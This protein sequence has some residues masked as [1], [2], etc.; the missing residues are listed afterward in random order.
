MMNK[1]LSNGVFCLFHCAV[2]FLLLAASCRAD[3]ACLDAAQR[4]ELPGTSNMYQVSDSLYRGA[5]PKA[6]GFKSLEALEIKTVVNLR[7]TQGDERYAG[8]ASMNLVGIPMFPWEPDEEDVIRFLKLTQDPATAP[9]F[10]H[11]RH[12]SDRTGALTAC[13]RVVVCGWPLEQA[14]EEMKNGGFGYHPI[15]WTLPR[16]LEDLDFDRIRREVFAQ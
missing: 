16:D 5:Q 12:G 7:I 9:V 8:D 2:L 4:K 6:E 13:Y 1:R 10:L 3:D 11:C 14:V 15:W